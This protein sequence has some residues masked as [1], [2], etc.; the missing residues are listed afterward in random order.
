MLLFVMSRGHTQLNSRVPQTPHFVPCSPTLACRNPA[1]TIQS[2][3]GKSCARIDHS[4][5][6]DAS[7]VHTCKVVHEPT[8][9]DH[10][11]LL[12]TL[13]HD[14]GSWTSGQH[15]PIS[16]LQQL[17]L[18]ELDNLSPVFQQKLEEA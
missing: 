14:F 13:Q 7:M 4:L 3:N 8:S 11:A 12:I 5:V 16:V 2:H 18:T 9:S 17:N 6:S 15:K 1:V 10:H